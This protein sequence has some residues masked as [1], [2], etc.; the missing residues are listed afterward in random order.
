MA[1]QYRHFVPE[2][3]ERLL[4]NHRMF[5]ITGRGLSDKE[6]RVLVAVLNSTLIAYFKTFYGRY[7]GTEGSLDTEV[8]DVNLMDVPDVRGLCNDLAGSL[9]AALA[10]LQRRSTIPL[11]ESEF[12]ACHT[13]EA[14]QELAQKP[15]ALSEELQQADRRALDDAVFRLLGIDNPDTRGRLLEELYYETAAHYRRIRIVEVQ[16][17][18][19]RAGGRKQRIR[20]EDVAGAIWNALADDERGPPVLQWLN[21]LTGPKTQIEVPEG[22]ASVLGPDNMLNPCGVDFGAGP[23]RIHM[24]YVSPQHA[25]LVGQLADLEIRGSF[26]VPAEETACQVALKDL[27][28]RLSAAEVR[29]RQAAAA[30]TGDDR[31]QRHVTDLLMHV[32]VHGKSQKTK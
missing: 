11:V 25:A 23:K 28:D 18:E 15:I 10:G 16:K 2:N 1:Q 13:A 6:S 12:M 8:L 26:E 4:C 5:Y 7:T 22:K 9:L 27:R 29:F 3:P 30:R 24:D 14:V 31:F 21:G 17:M 20:P 32:F 19:Q